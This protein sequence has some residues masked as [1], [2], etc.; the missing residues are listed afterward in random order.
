MVRKILLIEDQEQHI[1]DALAYFADVEDVELVIAQD[2]GEAREQYRKVVREE[3]SFESSVCAGD[4][5]GVISD[6]YFPLTLRSRQWD[7]PEPIGLRVALELE[8]LEIPFVLCTSGYHHGRRFEWI[9]QLAR[10]RGWRLVDSGTDYE[11]DAESKPWEE[12]HRS[13]EYRMKEPEEE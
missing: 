13:L 5:D 10:D 8:E 2:F 11:V 4:I 9:S 6:I 12:A 3:G 1:E 7:Q